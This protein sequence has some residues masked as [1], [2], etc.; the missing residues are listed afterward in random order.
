MS[1]FR[2]AVVTGT[3]SSLQKQNFCSLSVVVSG[4]R[5]GVLLVFWTFECL[6]KHLVVDV[7]QLVY[8]SLIDLDTMTLPNPLTQ[9]GLVAVLCLKVV[10]GFLPEANGVGA[11][12]QL[13][14]GIV[15]AV[16]GLWLFDLI[17]TGFNCAWASGDGWRRC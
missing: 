15:G 10:A 3:V 2:L 12:N 14:S 7:L 9:S 16:L 8:M 13:I 11:V 6:L 5:S 17:T 4:N 1:Q